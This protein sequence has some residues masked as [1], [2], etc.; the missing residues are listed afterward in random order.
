MTKDELAP[1]PFCGGS[2]TMLCDSPSIWGDDGKAWAV[3]CTVR[4]CHGAIFSLGHDLF[5]TPDEAITAWNTRATT[6]GEAK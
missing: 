2:R 5:K 6:T 3:T 4:D 1:C